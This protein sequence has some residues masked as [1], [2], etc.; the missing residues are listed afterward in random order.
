MHSAGLELTKLIYTRLEA[1]QIRHRGDRPSYRLGRE[2]EREMVH[3]REEN[4]SIWDKQKMKKKKK[5]RVLREEKLQPFASLKPA[6]SF[7]A[8]T[9]P[10]LRSSTGQTRWARTSEPCRGMTTKTDPPPVRILGR[11]GP[12]RDLIPLAT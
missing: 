6:G 2:K 3:T 1:N 7:V 12:N 8:R 9:C 5:R 4:I 11:P 10:R